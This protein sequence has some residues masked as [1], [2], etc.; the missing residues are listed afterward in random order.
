MSASS[1]SSIIPTSVALE[2]LEEFRRTSKLKPEQR[3]QIDE[4]LAK[5]RAPEE[6]VTAGESSARMA[7]RRQGSRGRSGGEPE[8]GL[9]EEEEAD[10]DNDDN[11]NNDNDDNDA[12]G[13]SKDLG[14]LRDRP[15]HRVVEEKGLVVTWPR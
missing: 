5:L 4:V 1:S 3:K 12:I 14:P 8:G 2:L 15:H 7:A 11:N 6:E 10:D 13:S 9:E